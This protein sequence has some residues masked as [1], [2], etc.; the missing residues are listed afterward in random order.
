MKKLSFQRNNWG[1]L[2]VAVFFIFSTAGLGVPN[3]ALAAKADST[4][5]LGY[6]N[7]QQVFAAYPGIQDIMSR[8]QAMRQAAQKDFDEHG[9][10]L[11]Q[12]EKTAYQNKLS[13][14]EA[15]RENEL[16]KPVGDKIKA[17]IESVKAEKGLSVIVD[18]NAIVSGGEDITAAVIEQ[19]KK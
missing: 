9:K 13:R 10:A 11:P 6:V 16:M 12:E 5:T 15:Q 8:I 19:E 2:L 4:A 7:R 18:A 14:E 1:G 17:A 3:Q